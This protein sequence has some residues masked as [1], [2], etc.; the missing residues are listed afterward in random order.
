MRAGKRGTYHLGM[1]LIGTVRSEPEA[2]PTRIEVEAATYSA[3]LEQ[4][5][6]RVPAGHQLIAIRVDRD[7]DPRAS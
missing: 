1:R 6:Q 2:E 5:E 7:D 3:A 4:L